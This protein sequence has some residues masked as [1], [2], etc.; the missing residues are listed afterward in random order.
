M[1]NWI[2]RVIKF[3]E[4][5]KKVIKKRPTKEEILESSW[6][7]C[8]AGPIRKE[9]IFND[10]TQHVCPKCN[11]HYPLTPKQ[12]FDFFFGKD[13]YTIIDTPKN[14]DDPLNW[15][16]NVYKKKL[17]A[18]RKLT[19]QHC[20][21]LVAQGIKD[22]INIT[23][24]A[25]DSRFIGG[26]INVAAGEAIVKACQVAIDSNNPLLAWSEGGGQ[27]MYESNLS[28][29]MMTKTVLAVNT[30]KSNNLPFINCY[31]NKCYGGI[32]ASFAGISDIAFVESKSTLV[33]FAGQH[34][35]KNQTNEVLPSNFQTASSLLQTGFVDAIYDRKEINDK[36]ISILK[37]LLHKHDA[38][39]E[40]NN[41]L[42]DETSENYKSAR[43]QAS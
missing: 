15:P 2:S 13:N 19:G 28:L 8:C 18:A 9:E 6:I 14:F 37:I 42:T 4:K 10:D 33:G 21:V 20:C 23:T 39:S 16:N 36:I 22:G 32:S 40:V 7:A 27:S 34:I 41:E 29:H 35:V 12:R 5:I 3:G 31:V 25:I 1:N 26:S 17:S 24:F 43:K 30:L 11:K 38:S